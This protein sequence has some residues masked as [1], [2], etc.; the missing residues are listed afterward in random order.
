[1]DTDGCAG[2]ATCTDSNDPLA[3]CVD[4]AAPQT[5]Y[6]C[7]CSKR[8]EIST[9][10][11][12][13]CQQ[14]TCPPFHF[15]QGVIGSN[16]NGNPCHDGIELTSYSNSQC[17]LEC[18]PGYTPANAVSVTYT[19]QACYWH[20]YVENVDWGYYSQSNGDCNWC[21]SQCENDPNCNAFECGSGYC[22]WWSKGNC[23]LTEDTDAHYLTGR[24]E[25]HGTALCGAQGGSASSSF[26][27]VEKSCSAYYFAE[28]VTGASSP[29][30]CQNGIQLT[31]VSDTSCLLSCVAGYTGSSS[32]ELSCGINA[33]AA[34]TSFQ[35]NEITC[36]PVTFA[37]GVTG[38]NSGTGCTV[39]EILSS[40]THSYCSLTCL[41]GYESSGH[42]SHLMNCGINGGTPSTAFVCHEKQ[43]AP[44]VLPVGVIGSTPDGCVN[45]QVL[46]TIN[47]N[48]CTL[49]CASTHEYLSGTGFEWY[50]I[51][52]MSHIRRICHK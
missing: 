51:V 3:S 8:F 46:T 34:I 40:I 52:F 16:A 50:R 9:D 19:H 25:N 11:S 30:G 36:S 14:R 45:G 26:Q 49:Q 4:K 22:S 29:D 7:S 32:N 5:G 2:H 6:T 24:F 43:C 28:G 39:S 47:D 44:L 10:S 18:A 27:C 48:S 35:C 12:P 37:L 15:P 38:A 21:K 17:D 41:P 42:S 31:T 33:G 23:Y 1:V 20:N 13:T